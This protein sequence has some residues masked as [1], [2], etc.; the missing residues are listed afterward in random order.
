MTISRPV[1][2]NQVGT[3]RGVPSVQTNAIRPESRLKKPLRQIGLDSVGPPV[4]V[5]G[6]V[7]LMRGGHVPALFVP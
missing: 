6:F 4:E 1:Q 7:R 5:P 2:W 3:T